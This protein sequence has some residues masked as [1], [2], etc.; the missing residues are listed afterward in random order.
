M[1]L[2]IATTTLN[3]DA[4]MATESLSPVSFY[5][6]RGFGISLFYPKA[7]F[8]LKN[9]ILLFDAFPHF[10]ISDQEV[11]H[12]QMVIEIDDSN[13]PVG[14]FKKVK[15]NDGFSVYQ[16]LS[17]LYI[18]PLSCKIYFYTERDRA[19]TLSKADSIIEAK[20]ALYK[21][22][23]V[24][25][26]VDS[27]LISYVSLN[28]TSLEGIVD[29][30]DADYKAMDFDRRVDKAKGFLVS[31]MMGASKAISA[32][33]VRL[34]RL[35]KD[36]KNSVYS[37][38]TK[39]KDV[40]SP[41]ALASLRTLTAEAETLSRSMDQ[42]KREATMRVYAFL[43]KIG[44]SEKL[45]GSSDDAILS[46]FKEA[47]V[48][49]ALYQKVN[50]PV[51]TFS[52]ESCVAAALNAEDDAKQEEAIQRM[53]AY[54]RSITCGV[55]F[56][57]KVDDLF[58]FDPDLRV[59]DCKDES[60]PVKSRENLNTLY[61]LFSG[62]NVS[63]AEIR[64]NRINYVVD[65]GEALGIADGSQEEK[66][67]FNALLDN[68]EH[69]ARFDIMSTSDPILQALAGF[70]RSPDKDID[71]MISSLVNSEVADPRAAYGL[72]GLFYGYSS[73]R[74]DY[75]DAFVRN[76]KDAADVMDF[77]TKVYSAIFNLVPSFPVIERK[78]SEPKEA[79]N[80]T[81][82]QKVK[83]FLGF[84]NS[85]QDDGVVRET[86]ADVD[87]PEDVFTG[88]IEFPEDTTSERVVVE[89]IVK[90]E[91]L[92]LETAKGRILSAT[93]AIPEPVSDKEDLPS[94]YAD[95]SEEL[96]NILQKK[97]PKTK[98]DSYLSYYSRNIIK[99]CNDSDRIVAI[100]NGLDAI[101]PLEAGR[102]SWE[103]TKPT[104]R[105]YLRKIEKGELL[106]KEAQDKQ[107]KEEEKQRARDL[108]LKEKELR[109]EEMKIRRERYM[110]SSYSGQFFNDPNAW[111]FIEDLIPESVSQ[112]VEKDIHWFQEEYRFGR[113]AQNSKENSNVL[114]ILQD[115]LR[116]RKNPDS[117]SK[118]AWVAKYYADVDVD[119]VM[120]RLREVYR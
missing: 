93:S 53:Q 27:S 97:A 117:N 43:R 81:V 113:Y 28:R 70:M 71:K 68:L 118:M 6:R 21:K 74:K 2:F 20:Y 51:S 79:K 35:V 92:P 78:K 4:I 65:A 12:R 73:I 29:S 40:S 101:P 1:R 66:D 57:A 60:L 9:S 37:I 26:V 112:Q 41:A 64:T 89:E 32:D 103:K 48:Y 52:I 62:Y 55:D 19:T 75:F 16:A 110:N 120:K 39:E 119:S 63:S 105:E 44:A 24:L 56:S 80:E 88:M 107:R 15:D 108:K 36:I 13:Y 100:I 34:L 45:N 25:E 95:L 77:V 47:G 96:I 59:I 111:L 69:A 30:P 85:S 86:S 31:Y 50:G 17:T 98:T 94:V 8:Q 49:G 22:L 3:F 91:G 67:Y 102:S 42:R 10:K 23:G 76:Y 72:W 14:T 104:L 90:G 82:L 58:A 7:S 99:L 109:L 11:E 54:A 46:V 38:G 84:S 116:R 87:M 114:D 18:S 106:A 33:S 5:E 83:Q 61:N 115:Y